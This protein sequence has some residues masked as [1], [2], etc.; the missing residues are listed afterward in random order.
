M[1]TCDKPVAEMATGDALK[2]AWDKG[3]D[4]LSTVVH[5]PGSA[6]INDWAL[7]FLAALVLL[8]L[9]LLVLRLLLPSRPL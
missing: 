8:N 3:V 4:A 5:S 6:S 9:L 2:C 7:A 1:E